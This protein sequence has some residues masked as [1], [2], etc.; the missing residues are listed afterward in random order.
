MLNIFAPLTYETFRMGTGF[1]VS[2]NSFVSNSLF[3]SFSSKPALNAH[4]K[5][6][7]H[8]SRPAGRAGRVSPSEV[9]SKG[10]GRP[11]KPASSARRSP[12]R[13]EQQEGVF[14]CKLC[15]RY[16]NHLSLL[17]IGLFF[18]TTGVINFRINQGFLIEHLAIKHQLKQTNIS[19]IKYIKNCFYEKNRLNVA[20]NLFFW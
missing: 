15:G 5:I 10:P 17:K 18:S 1:L 20:F 3:Q 12:V 4:L 8:S 7:I 14:P 13:E 6:H 2:N 11:T 19:D 16:L 9:A